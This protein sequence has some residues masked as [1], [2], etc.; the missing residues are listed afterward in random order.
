MTQ[1]Y[2]APLFPQR[3]P[4]H[5]IRHVEQVPQGGALIIGRS[6]GG[7][8]H[9][10]GSSRNAGRRRWEYRPAP[11]PVRRWTRRSLARSSA[12]GCSARHRSAGSTAPRPNGRRD[13]GRY[14]HRLAGRC[15][16]ADEKGFP[17][18]IVPRH[19]VLARERV[20]GWQ[21]REQRFVPDAAC[22]AIGKLMSPAT[23]RCRADRREVGR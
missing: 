11:S 15:P 17:G 4:A 8:R 10:S 3:G 9:G 14:G 6:D 19:V 21:D 20:I 23:K 2:G 13:A 1:L 22:V 18:Q 16:V 7:E 12:R 5:G